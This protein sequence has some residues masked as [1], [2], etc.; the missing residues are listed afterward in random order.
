L[1]ARTEVQAYLRNK[2]NSNDNS[3]HNSNNHN[4]SNSNDNNSNRNSE[5]EI[6]YG[7]DNKKSNSNCVLLPVF[8]QVLR[9]TS[10]A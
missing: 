2:G 10:Q 3:N 6:P 5:K 8:R 1:N 4:N 9:T 7:D